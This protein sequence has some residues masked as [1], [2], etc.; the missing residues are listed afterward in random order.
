MCCSGFKVRLKADTK[1][2]CK[3]YMGL[4]RPVDGRP[5]KHVTL[6]VIQF[7]VVDLFCYLGDEICPRGGCVPTTTAR[8]RAVLGKFRGLLLLLRFNKIS[9]ARCGKLYDSR[10]RGT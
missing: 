1:Y 6:E 5:E 4:C 10:V 2:R 9:L 7:N 3:R 8:T